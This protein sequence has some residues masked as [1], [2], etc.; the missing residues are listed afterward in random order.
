MFW[1][2]IAILFTTQRCRAAAI[3]H[4]WEQPEL[5]TADVR[6]FFWKFIPV[7]DRIG[8]AAPAELDSCTVTEALQK[9]RTPVLWY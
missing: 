9:P 6:Q 5:M 1:S 4:F 2:E 8:L 3:S 7:P